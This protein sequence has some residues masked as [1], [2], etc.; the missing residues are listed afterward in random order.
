MAAVVATV[1]DLADLAA[2]QRGVVSQRLTV[3]AG[4]LGEV[5]VRMDLTRTADGGRQ[6]QVVVEAAEA[7]A[8]AALRSEVVGLVEGL[9]RRG[10][11]EPVVEVRSGGGVDSGAREQA[12]DRGSAHERREAAADAEAMAA[13]VGRRYRDRA[14]GQARGVEMRRSVHVVV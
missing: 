1:T 7:Q 11:V 14:S 9:E 13:A 6:L 2:L 5:R 4:A 10:Y 3:D 12:G 8:A